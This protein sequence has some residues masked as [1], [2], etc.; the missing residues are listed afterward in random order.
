[1]VRWLFRAFVLLVALGAITFGA[2]LW[3]VQ[4]YT[5]FSSR[6]EPTRLEAA[7]ARRV[8]H[9]SIPADLR[10]KTNPLPATADNLHEGME[11]FA[12]HCALCHANNGAGDTPIGRGLYPK[13]PVL[14]EART[15]SLSDGE[16]FAIIQNGIR[17]TG[18]PAFGGGEHTD[19]DSWKCVLFIR[20]LPRITA[21]ELSEMEK[22]NPK[23]PD[24]MPE[25]P[26]PAGSARP[27]EPKAP[28]PHTHSHGGR[29][30][31]P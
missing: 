5:P 11:H 7:V 21:T 29:G 17:F 8:R 13:P 14:R 18:M 12:D 19:E 16:L 15:Q 30:E 3:Y 25:I 4:H 9:L 1:M 20:H 28:A 27:A 24:D 2:A 6:A 22:L 26:A 31:N 23:A 10:A